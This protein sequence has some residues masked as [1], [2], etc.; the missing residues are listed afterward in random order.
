[1]LVKFGQILGM[2]FLPSSPDEEV[3]ELCLAVVTHLLDLADESRFVLRVP[4]LR[5]HVAEHPRNHFH[6]SPDLVIGLGGRTRLEFA[7]GEITLERHE[8]AVIPAGIP[9]REIPIARAGEPFQNLIVSTYNETI[10]AQLQ[11]TEPDAQ[12]LS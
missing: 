8:I 7:D 1:M 12:T 2:S 5:D 3:W 10:C 4:R 9:H 6:F 11:R